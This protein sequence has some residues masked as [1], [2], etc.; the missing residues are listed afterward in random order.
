MALS[1][2][3]AQYLN[4]KENNPG[5]LLLFRL[6]D[7]YELFFDDAI[8]ASKELDLVLTGRDC[9]LNER[10]PMCG[11]PFHAVDG[12][13]AKLV[14]KGYKVAICEQLNN[15]KKGIATREIVRVITP[16]TVM[17]SDMLTADAN[18]YL[19]SVCLED[20]KAGVCWADISTGEFNRM[21]IDAAIAIK[22]NDLL[23]RIKPSEIICNG[24]MKMLSRN[25]SA[26]K[27]GGLCE[28]Q[29]I[30]ETEFN[31]D[32]AREIIP[33]MCK[34]SA[35]IL[36]EET[37]CVK[38]CGALLR[39]VRQTQK[40]DLKYIHS[41][42]ND[43]KTMTID[44]IAL[45][46]L[47]ITAPA[48]GK[49]Q[50]SLYSAVNKT[51]TGMG[52]RLLVKRLTAPS[53]DV[54]TINLRL[55]GTEELVNDKILRGEVA[56]A[57]SG[58]FD[59]ERISTRI[60]YGNITPKEC[61]ALANSLDKLP[62]LKKAVSS[63]KSEIITALRNT[64][65]TLTDIADELHSAIKS[66]PSTFVRD[67]GVINDGY[68]KELDEY[69]SASKNS[70]AILAEIEA[71]EK[72]RT[73]IKNM[74]VGY[75]SV[76]GYYIEVSKS[77]T[78][79]V[80]YEYVR[81]QTT[82]NAERYITEELKQIEDKILHAEERA[83]AI[84]AELYSALIKKLSAFCDRML[85]TA[86][87]VANIDVLYSSAEVAA[88]YRYT[89]PVVT[90]EN[91]NINIKEGRHVTV[92]RIG[93][94]TFVPNDTFLNDNDSRT[95]IITGPN[96]AGKSVYMRQVALIVILAQAGFFVP[97]DKAEIG[98]VDRIFTRVGA[99]DDLH[100]GRSTFMVEMSEV[101]HI[102]ENATDN[103]LIL[104]DEV[105]RGTAT[106]DGLSIAWSII[107]YLSEKFKAK[108][109][110]ST[111][112]HELTDLEGVV[113]GVKNYKM[114]VRELNGNIIFM[115][116]LMRGSANRSFGIEVAGLSGLP[117]KVIDGAK[118]HLKKLEKLN[119]AR[120]NDSAYQQ[121]SLFNADKTN[122]I[123]KILE[124]INMDDISPRNAYDILTDLK[125][126]AEG[127]K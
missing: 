95:M 104:L 16:G 29:Q 19:L 127:E 24:E 111:H 91:R 11:V 50:G 12:Y 117:K 83:L 26:V 4:I 123:L 44:S 15:P 74:R 14:E 21:T 47:E 13:I 49:K 43:E 23:L 114:T 62:I 2:M 9:G 33:A 105:G 28:F 53:T 72:E 109:L 81:K 113:D 122:E 63:C 20:G 67:G 5:C 92:E 56:D 116:K 99:S 3:M 75:N 65:D 103:S 57:L 8:T 31:I 126:K 108:T 73:G 36:K 87:I 42:E 94:E 1:P 79:L 68:N 51:L 96:M 84:E 88:K 90:D 25:L 22:L 17:E 64:L 46:T 115:R 101:A 118:L 77:Q 45:S 30:D 93:T 78:G 80:P 85:A 98:I 34:D 10:A 54:Q 121:I 124:E 112:Y 76:F 97:A 100:T 58:I 59:I 106:Y 110:F 119:V 71:K 66:D 6:G 69:R 32:N 35:N 86:F 41:N 125:E 48:N 27:Y 39:Y 18:N 89:K 40:R 70:K 52:A 37:V 60:A 107:E 82:A 102:L 38:A 61:V 7:F 55:D 120:Q